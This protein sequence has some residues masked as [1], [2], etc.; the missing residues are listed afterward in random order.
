MTVIDKSRNL[1]CINC[2]TLA[3][4]KPIGACTNGVSTLAMRCNILDEY[5]TVKKKWDIE[6]MYRAFV[7]FDR[8]V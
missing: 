7:Y 2:I 6:F 8:G 3:I 5:L 1:P 4:C